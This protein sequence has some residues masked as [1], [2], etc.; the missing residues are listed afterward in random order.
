MACRSTTK[1]K[2]SYLSC[3][4]EPRHGRE[5]CFGCL[6]LCQ[7]KRVLDDRLREACFLLKEQPQVCLLSCT[8]QTCNEV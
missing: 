8:D 7:H 3:V 2:L 6:I 1:K 5:A 4:S